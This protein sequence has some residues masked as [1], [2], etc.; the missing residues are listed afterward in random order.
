[1]DKEKEEGTNGDHTGV[2]RREMGREESKMGK[3]EKGEGEKGG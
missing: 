1:M 3:D 2:R